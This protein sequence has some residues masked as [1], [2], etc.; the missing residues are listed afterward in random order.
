MSGSMALTI[1]HLRPPFP[2]VARELQRFCYGEA[3][4][5]LSVWSR[6]QWETAEGELWLASAGGLGP[7]GFAMIS[8]HGAEG[9]LLTLGVRPE[10]RGQG[11]GFQLLQALEAAHPEVTSWFL[12]V[13]EGNAPAQS[14]YRRLGWLRVGERPRYYPDGGSAL[15]LRKDTTFK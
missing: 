11:V 4:P 14:L 3:G 1:D 12:E 5:G 8:V 10:A 15:L 2:E 9:E 6:Q 13:H 7:V